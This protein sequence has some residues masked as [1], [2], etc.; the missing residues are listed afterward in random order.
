MYDHDSNSNFEKLYNYRA[1]F[2]EYYGR[3]ERCGDIGFRVDIPTFLAT[4]QAKGFIDW[5]Q[6]V[7]CIFDYKDVE[8]HIKAKLVTKKLKGRVSSQ[9]G[10]LKK[11]QE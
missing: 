10:Q 5:L 7:E 6:E 2:Q 3:E 11:S 8:D 4:L 1:L 9:W